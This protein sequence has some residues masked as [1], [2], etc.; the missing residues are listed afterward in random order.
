MPIGWEVAKAVESCCRSMGYDAVAV[1]AVPSR[2]IWG[3]LQPRR[4]QL[5]MVG[6]GSSIEAIHALSYSFECRAMTGEP[7]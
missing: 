5:K 1:R 7:L 4:T 6:E 2:D 3:K